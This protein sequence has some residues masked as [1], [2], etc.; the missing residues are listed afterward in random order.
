MQIDRTNCVEI[1]IQEFPAFCAQWD[2]YLV[3][4]NPLIERPLAVDLAEFAD[5]ALELIWAGDGSELDRLATTI[6]LMLVEG[7]A[8]VKYAVRKILLEKLASSSTIA[9]FP[10]ELFISKLQPQ[11][12]VRWQ[13]LAIE[14]G[15]D[16]SIHH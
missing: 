16:L 13:A 7:D 3:S 1:I 4:W 9:G 8:V 2:S 12:A 6:E 10:I 11:T 14:R 5:F 15:I